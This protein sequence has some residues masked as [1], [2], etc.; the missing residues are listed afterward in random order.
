MIANKILTVLSAPVALV[1]LPLQFVTTL[2]GGI[3]VAITFG[4]LLI[5]ISAIWIVLFYGPLLGLSWV[6]EKVEPLPVLPLLV[7]IVGVPLAILGSEY[8]ALM[9]S[10]G[11]IE[12]RTEKLR[13]C[14][15]WPFT[16]EYMG[17]QRGELENDYERWTRMQEV[18]YRVKV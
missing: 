7:A 12:S 2:I 11:E 10:M 1:T 15:T 9:P 5:P 18:L 17:F 3:L 8:V 13:L 6:W 16:L 4:L 14:W